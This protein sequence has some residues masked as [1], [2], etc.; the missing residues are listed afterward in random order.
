MNSIE[1]MIE[2]T[3]ARGGD[4]KITVEHVHR[5]N[6]HELR[7]TWKWPGMQQS[8][9]QVVGFSRM[10]VRDERRAL[11]HGIRVLVLDFLRWFEKFEPPVIKLIN[12][13]TG[14]RTD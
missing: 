6:I 2:E 4:F 9:T 7:M 14:R 10:D 13:L 1:E 3:I 11:K 5:L 8:M 12:A